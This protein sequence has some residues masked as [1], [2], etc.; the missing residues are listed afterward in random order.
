MS[1]KAEREIKRRERARMEDMRDVIS[2]DPRR[3]V[4]WEHMDMCWSGWKEFE[5]RS[6]VDGKAGRIESHRIR[7][8]ELGYCGGSNADDEDDAGQRRENWIDR[9]GVSG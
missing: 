8:P 7:H 9:R 6:D 1:S 5:L 3:R 2:T 4:M